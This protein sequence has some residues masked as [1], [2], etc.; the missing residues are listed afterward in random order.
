MPL[1]PILIYGLSLA[2]VAAAYWLA[3][4]LVKTYRLYFLSSYSGY[5]VTLNIIALLN[6]VVGY[7]ATELLKSLS[8]PDLR[9]VYILFG[10][11]AFPILAMTFYFFLAFIAGILDRELSLP[12]RISY[13]VFWVILFAGFLVRIQLSLQQR[14]L[15]VSQSLGLVTGSLIVLVPFAAMIYLAVGSTSGSPV[16]EKK[17]L[18]TFSAI[19]LICFLL[20][21]AALTFSQ[22]KS[23]LRWSVPALLFLSNAGQILGLRRFLSRHGRPI[24]P[25]TLTPV[26]M[27]RFRDESRLSTREGEVLDLL[28]NGKSNKDI[29]RELFISHHTVRNHVHNIYQKLG[30]SSRLQLMNRIRTWLEPGA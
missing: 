25:E 6:L 7:I 30:V 18:R 5:L 3:L 9:T 19:S 13:I 1:E 4:G 21:A 15:R 11:V 14:H 16:E 26:K 10:L 2:A 29:E 12:F 20:F 23:P 24:L 17:G 22:A 27:Q 8:P 28:L